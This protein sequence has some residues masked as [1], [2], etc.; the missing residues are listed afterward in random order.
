MTATGSTGRRDWADGDWGHG[1]WHRETPSRGVEAICTCAPSWRLA[2]SLLRDGGDP[3]GPGSSPS[4]SL[5]RARQQ[6]AARRGEGEGDRRDGGE[7]GEGT[8][9]H[10]AAW[11]D[12]VSAACSGP[13]RPRS[14]AR[15]HGAVR[16]RPEQDL[17]RRRGGGGDAFLRFVRHLFGHDGGGGVGQIRGEGSVLASC[18]VKEVLVHSI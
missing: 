10:G 12:L 3:P 6:A 18:P 4:R 8:A 14:A 17:A 5:V 9:L 1:C 2:T 7:G 11:S 16:A 13:T 15:R